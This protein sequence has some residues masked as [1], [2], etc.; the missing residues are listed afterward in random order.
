MRVLF[1]LLDERTPVKEEAW[2]LLRRLPPA[3]SVL[4][5]LLTLE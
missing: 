2:N 1:S 5:R 4:H 3:P